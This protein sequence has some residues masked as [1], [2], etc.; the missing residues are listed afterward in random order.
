MTEPESTAEL[1]P[2]LTPRQRKLYRASALIRQFRAEKIDFLHTVQCQTGI[3]YV[4][5]GD[6]TRVWECKQGHAHLSMEAGRALDPRVGRYVDLGLPYG[7]KPRLVLIYLASEA[8]RTTSPIIDVE[9]SMTAFARSVGFA[10]NGP[11]LRSLKEQLSRLAAAT[12]RMGFVEEGRAVQVNTQIV[13]ALDLWYPKE[14]GQ[15]VLW[16][17]TVQLSTDYYESLARH[18]VPLDRRA[19]AALSGSAMALDV[20]AWLAQ[21]LRRI[22]RGRPAFIPW[23][24]LAEQFGQEFTRVRDFRRLFLR[25]LFQVR[26]VYPDARLDYDLGGLTLEHSL[27][28][29]LSNDPDAL[30]LALE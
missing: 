28:P 27:P 1:L 6:D 11:Q 7:E 9:R 30:P 22:E 23:A 8:M 2:S 21:R 15:H 3:P 4:N 24:T 16:P 20:Y 13:K 17:S 10:T 5:P 14:P 26:Q 25:T 29:V 12:I 19:V 18:A